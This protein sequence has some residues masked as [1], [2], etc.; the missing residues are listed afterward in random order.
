[1]SVT[2]L[3]K[4]EILSLLLKN[5]DNYYDTFTIYDLRA[6]KVESVDEYKEKIS[7]Q[8]KLPNQK[9]QMRIEQ[10]TKI[11]DELFKNTQLDWFNGKKAGK[12]PWKIAYIPGIK[13]EHGLPHT[14]NDVI[15]LTIT[16]HLFTT[17]VHEKVHLYQKRYPNDV[18]IYLLQK[19]FERVRKREKKDYIRANPD[20][21]KWIY[22]RGK[23]IYKCVYK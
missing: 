7:K 8:S 20:I 21:D 17:L 11:I 1:M 10:Y 16:Y 23:R 14:R 6:R 3:S 9:L 15:I 18:E 4:P 2:F 13:Y 22:K 19:G 5:N 12:I